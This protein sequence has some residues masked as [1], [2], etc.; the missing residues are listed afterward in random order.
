MYTKG[1]GHM[2][3][4]HIKTITKIV[5]KGWSFPARYSENQ[6][7]IGRRLLD[8]MYDFKLSNEHE[9]QQL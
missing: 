4:L 9:T 6:K 3:C 2:V 8:S 7:E 5:N 1:R